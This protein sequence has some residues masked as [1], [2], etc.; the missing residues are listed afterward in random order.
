M[1][2]LLCEFPSMFGLQKHS[3]RVPGACPEPPRTVP[4]RLQTGSQ[5]N[6]KKKTQKVLTVFVEFALLGSLS[7]PAGTPKST[8]NGPGAEKVRPETAPE[9]IFCV[10]LRRCCSESVSGPISGGPDP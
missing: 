9:A 5:N 10:F 8:K 2:E 4:K 1:Q 3:R 7:D 6:F